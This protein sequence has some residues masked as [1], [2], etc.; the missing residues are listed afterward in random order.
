[1]SS[2]STVADVVVYGATSAGVAAAIAVGRAGRRALL[3]EPGRHAGGLSSGGLGATDYGEKEAVGGFARE[4]YVGIKRHYLNSDSWVFERPEEYTSHG[5]DWNDDA[6]W[7]FEPHVAERV[8]RE[9]LR[10]AGVEIVHGERLDL[11]HGVSKENRAITAM[12]T[13]SGRIYRGRIYIDATY[14]GDLMACAGVSYT[15]GRESNGEYGETQNGFRSRK[16]TREEGGDFGGHFMRAVDPY[17]IPG[18][19]SSGL[20]AGVH[21]RER[22]AEGTTDRR[23]QAYNYRLCLTNV[24]ANRVPVA[25]PAGYDSSRY[26]LLLRYLLSDERL[27]RMPD[28]PG[29][30][31]PVLGTDVWHVIMP[32]RKTD[33]NTKGAFGSDCVGTNWE[34]PDANYE[35]RQRIITDQIEYHKG[36]LWFVANDPRVPPEYRLPMQEWGFAADEFTDTDHWPHQLYV[37]EARRMVGRYVMTEHNCTGR[38]VVRDPICLAS[39]G[40]DSHMTSRYVDEDGF[41]QN[42]GHVLGGVPRPY[43]VSWRATTPQEAECDNL[44]VPVCLSASHPAYGSIR[45]EPV[46]MQLGHA[47]ATGAILALESGRTVANVDYGMLKERLL[48]DGQILTWRE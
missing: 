43:P 26:E 13:E 15:V 22:A 37:R 1:M 12:T 34:Y 10:E 45:M 9:M 16:W 18:D 46:F 48:A 21:S 5:H 31:H 25:R 40:M 41:V 7:R 28:L 32:N 44:L 29:P 27:P 39:Y 11:N 8:F 14:E 30:E 42:E 36:L 20:L 17:V 3:I 19:T 33:S 23:V 24:A 2:P 47:A 6:M 35:T 4:F 38:D